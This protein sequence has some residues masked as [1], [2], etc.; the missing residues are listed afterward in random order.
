[1][2]KRL[3]ILVAIFLIVV[4]V[5]ADRVGAI[6]AAQVLSSKLKTDEHL[7]S[8][9]DVTVAGI[10]FLTQAV[11]GSYSD[12]KVTVTDLTIHRLLL[13]TLVV[14]LHGAHIGLRAALKGDV[15]EVPVDTANGQVTV[16]YPAI[17]AYLRGRH[18]TVSEGSGGQLKVTGALVIAGHKITASGVGTATIAHNVI[19]VHVHQ[20]SAGV[21]SHVGHLSLA[22]R[23]NF[24]LPLNGLPFRIALGTV[25][26]TPTGIIAT[27]T[28]RN[29]VLGSP[30]S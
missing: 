29:L 5:V 28:A 1:V 3:L 17:D 22:Q 18:L 8:R 10:P 4:V 12:V 2:F 16:G 7:P 19:D 21:G 14:Q 13:T 15:H 30:E 23:I 20:V 9:P 6:V 25:R 11:G 27:G 24:K 26:A